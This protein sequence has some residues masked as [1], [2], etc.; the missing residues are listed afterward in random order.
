MLLFDRVLGHQGV[1]EA[2]KSQLSPELAAEYKG[3]LGHGRLWAAL[4]AVLAIDPEKSESDAVLRAS[5]LS[6][7]YR[8]RELIDAADAAK[9]S[10]LFERS[11]AADLIAK[12]L[13]VA[14]N[15][16]RTVSALTEYISNQRGRLLA[17]QEKY[18]DRSQ[19]FWSP[20][21]GWYR[22]RQGGVGSVGLSISLKSAMQHDPR[23]CESVHAVRDAWSSADDAADTRV[24]NDVIS[25]SSRL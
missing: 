8:S 20:W 7:A 6:L 1:L 22:P 24:S 14:A 11:V 19:L 25:K 17:A 4:L 18:L 9:L 2:Y 5:A 21:E 10:A 15:V 12:A 3:A 23:V 16:D 13:G